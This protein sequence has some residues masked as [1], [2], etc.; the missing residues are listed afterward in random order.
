MDVWRLTYMTNGAQSVI[1]TGT[2]GM[3]RFSVE[4]SVLVQETPTTTLI[5][6]KGQAKCGGPCS[7]VRGTRRTWMPVPTKAGKSLTPFTAELTRMTLECSAILMVIRIKG[8]CDGRN[9]HIY[10]SL[11]LC[12]KIYVGIWCPL[13]NVLWIMIEFEG[14][15]PFVYCLEIVKKKFYWCINAS[16]V[17]YEFSFWGKAR[18][19]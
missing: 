3:Q 9:V 8:L 19:I 14:N 12:I 7:T 4:C 16:T 15:F 17:M 2:R 13:N 1:A 11:W 6:T 5:K 18:P 10:T